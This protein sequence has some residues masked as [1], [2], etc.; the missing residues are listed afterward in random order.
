MEQLIEE[1]REI[2][3]APQSIKMGETQL[4][5]DILLSD[6]S[7]FDD[8]YDYYGELERL[9]AIDEYDKVMHQEALDLLAE[10]E[11]VLQNHIY[12]H[13]FFTRRT[14]S[15]AED[16]DLSE[17]V[18]TPR[19]SRAGRL[20]NSRKPDIIKVHTNFATYLWFGSQDKE[21]KRNIGLFTA[22]K[23]FST[24]IGMAA[25][26]NFFAQS[27]LISAEKELPKLHAIVLKAKEKYEKLI[28]EYAENNIKVCIF[29]SEKP[30]QIEVLMNRYIGNL[31]LL[32]TS[33]D[34]LCCLFISLREKGLL[35]SDNDELEKISQTVRKFCL[36]ISDMTENVRDTNGLTRR[37]LLT[38][39]PD[40]VADNLA[41]AIEKEYTG[42][43]KQMT[44]C[45]DCMSFYLLLI[46]KQ[47]SM[48]QRKQ[49]THNESCGFFIDF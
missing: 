25:K 18:I 34:K 7:P 35:S 13:D 12:K 26:D 42:L 11:I 39:T 4:G 22:A 14:H 23:N 29:E 36:K 48:L 31:V 1:K 38:N 3:I 27:V 41:K 5:K 10:R 19:R 2:V 43:K 9:Q 37:S 28:K 24:L 44:T 20:R 49:I 47:Q 15:A 16:I 17:I 21:R 46:P 30:S 45:C 32:L 8:K 40:G 33:F 6:E